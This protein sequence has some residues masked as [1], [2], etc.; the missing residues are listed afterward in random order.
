MAGSAGGLSDVLRDLARSQGDRPGDERREKAEETPVDEA[1]RAIEGEGGDELLMIPEGEI[2]GEIQAE[3]DAE[4]EDESGQ[5]MGGV[6]ELSEPPSRSEAAVRAPGARVSEDR[7]H[8]VAA[9]GARV[10]ASGARVP[11][12]RAPGA[13]KK[14]HGIKPTL[15]PI[16]LTVGGLLMVPGLWALGILMEMNL[17]GSDRESARSMAALMLICIPMSLALEATALAFV[18][19]MRKS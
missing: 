16:M 5:A 6:Y 3:L 7:S 4:V 12:A 19:Q 9:R 10:R 8:T 13:V 11:G 15:V 17:P 1:L 18:I 14:D 2:E